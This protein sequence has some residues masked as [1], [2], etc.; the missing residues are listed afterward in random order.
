MWPS[1]QRRRLRQ[2]QLDHWICQLDA[3]HYDLSLVGTHS[4]RPLLVRR[5]LGWLM[6]AHLPYSA[7]WISD[8]LNDWLG[9]RGVIFIAAIFSLIAPFGM[10]VSQTWGQLAA[11]R[12]LL[13]IG[14]GLKEVTV[15]VFSAENAPAI[16]RGGLVMSWQMWTAF[17]KSEI[18]S[19]CNGCYGY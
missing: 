7:G 13:G 2:E 4:N 14:M 6:T 10:G 9:R 12:M 5:G 8:P 15:P 16:I 11:S 3:V 17:G 1:S 18:P 19:V